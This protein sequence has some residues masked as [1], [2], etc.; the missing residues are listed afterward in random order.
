MN[1]VKY[2]QGDVVMYKV[3]DKTYEQ[4]TS[5]SKSN[6]GNAFY[7]GGT[8]TT[9]GTGG[10]GTI[11]I[12]CARASGTG[13]QSL[14]SDG[15]LVSIRDNT[16]TRFLFDVEG[17]FH[18]DVESTTY[19]AYNDAHLVR[20]YDLSHGK[21]MIESKFD[22]FINYNHETL[23]DLRLTG[24][25]KDGTPN[26]FINIP[27]MQRLHNGA[28]WQQYTEMQKM[29][30]MMYETMVEL[31]GK[32]KADERLEAHDISLLENKDLIN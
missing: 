23:A 14:G 25:D 5:R 30:E 11:D 1:Y 32:E 19:D 3:D 9:K 26:R 17:S 16:T 4:H 28:I 21:G 27:G 18:A 13:L 15:N 12:R 29:K 6:D 20:A 2:Q 10:A 31:I 8:N 7:A 24:R 22:E